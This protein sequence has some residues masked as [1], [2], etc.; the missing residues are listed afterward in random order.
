MMKDETTCLLCAKYKTVSCEICDAPFEDRYTPI[1]SEVEKKE[2]GSR[3]QKR[4]I[5]IWNRA[6]QACRDSFEGYMRR[7]QG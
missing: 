2:E 5:R 7:R 1:F 3:E 6:V 4:K